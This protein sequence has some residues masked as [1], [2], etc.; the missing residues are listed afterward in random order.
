V[1]VHTYG[2]STSLCRRGHERPLSLSLPLS[3]CLSLSLSL[4]L[5]LREIREQYFQGQRCSAARL[6]VLNSGSG[7]FG[8]SRAAP[9]FITEVDGIPVI[10]VESDFSSSR[11]R[12][13]EREERRDFTRRKGRRSRREEALIE[14][15]DHF[16][17][18]CPVAGD[19]HQLVFMAAS[20]K[21]GNPRHRWHKWIT[22]CRF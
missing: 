8:A 18:R 12:E 14:I 5:A 19:R 1:Y 20:Q 2:I 13:R 21:E 11:E 6:A 10:I 9:T 4:S 16:A 17:K 22:H 7:R 15:R 3:L